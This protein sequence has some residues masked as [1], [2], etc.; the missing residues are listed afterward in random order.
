MLQ[1][2]E[3]H[4]ATTKK[5]TKNSLLM[6]SVPCGN[7]KHEGRWAECEKR[8][9]IY[10]LKE[11][12]CT[13][14]IFKQNQKI[15]WLTVASKIPGRSLKSCSDK[16]H[17]LLENGEIENIEIKAEET[18]SPM[19]FNKM[20]RKAF[21][22]SQ[23]KAL[24]NKIIDKIDSG[25]LV[26]TKDISMMAIDEFYSPLN[27]TMKVIVISFLNRMQWPFDKNGNIDIPNIESEIG[28]ILP[29]AEKHPYDLIDKYGIKNFTASPSWTY[30]FIKRNNLSI[31]SAHYERRGAINPDE[32]DQFLSTLADFLVRYSPECIFNMD[33]TFI[34]VFNC[35]VNAIVRKSAST[36]K[37]EKEKYDKKERTAYL[38]T[39]SMDPTKRLPLFIVTR[40]GSEVYERKFKFKDDKDKTSHTVNGWTTADLMIKYLQ[41]LSLQND[42][43]PCALLLD[44]S[45]AHMQD[46]AKMEAQKL[47]IE[48]VYIPSCGTSI[49][50]PLDRFVFGVLK[51]KLRATDIIINKSNYKQRFSIVHKT[52]SEIWQSLEDNLISKAWEIPG[53]IQYVY[54]DCDDK[55]DEDYV[56][57]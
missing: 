29:M 54:K 37:I 35:P 4:N 32:V 46:K 43:K 24:Y 33:V 36:V 55:N 52:V 22:P 38:S 28:L 19:E 5:M 12:A 26:T 8:Q 31:R 1:L 27:L 7:C 41:W 23:E 13:N 25:E 9:L 15:D 45:R 39:I 34:N 30:K 20:F 48:L 2:S 3:A 18:L 16:Y 10:V 40:G 44:S 17:Q 57:E 47:N 11:G 14:S 51:K 6:K 21:Y 53:L 50:Q 42:G 49:Y 56:D